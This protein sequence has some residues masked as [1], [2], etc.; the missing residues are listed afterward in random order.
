MDEADMLGDRIAIISNGK[1]CC[2][3]SSLYLKNQLGTGYY[4]T[5]VK[6]DLEPSL[7]S[8]RNSSSTMSYLKKEDSVS[9]SSSD[10]GLGS[11]QESDTIT[12]DVSAISNLILKHI[13]KARLVE[14]I[15]HELTYVLPYEAAK[16]GAFVELFHEIDDRLS[17]L[18]ISSYGISDTTL[19][20]A[21]EM[22]HV[23]QLW[24]RSLLILSVIG[25]LLGYSIAIIFLK[26]AEDNGVDAET[27]D[28]MIPA[29]RNRRSRFVDRQSCL[30]P[31]TDDAADVNDS[32]GDP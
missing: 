28:G 26:V 14:D 15:G 4:L 31:F 18:G 23:S 11:D 27:S 30:R 3:G 5:L 6:K 7:S 24:W 19:E 2:C 8:C 1:L 12:I 13:P 25:P 17:D 10:A 9:Q 29:C 20:E 32:D 22:Y 21:H 16:D